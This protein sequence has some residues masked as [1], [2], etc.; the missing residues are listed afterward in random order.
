MDNSPDAR[1]TESSWGP[2]RRL[3]YGAVLAAAAAVVWFLVDAAPENR[4]VAVVLAVVCAV[5]AV[6]LYRIRVRLRARRDGIVVIGPLRSR[7]IAWADIEVIAT[8]RRGRFGRHATWL[9]LEIRPDPGRGSA[10]IDD[11]V[12]EHP[13]VIDPRGRSPMGT[14]PEDEVPELLAFGAFDLGTDP[15]KVGAA[16]LRLRA[17]A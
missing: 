15:A 14:G 1:S 2:D 8:P 13:G 6:L 5:V 16:L 12:T 11:G 9:E 7:R 3:F 17:G 4:L 10:S